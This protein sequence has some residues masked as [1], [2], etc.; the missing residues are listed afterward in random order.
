M[1][2]LVP[3]TFK[4]FGVTLRQVFRSRSR[5]S[6]RSSSGRST[7]ASAAATGCT[8]TR[9]GSR[10]ASA[11]RSAPPPARPT[12]SASSP[13]R[14]PPSNRVSP[15]ERYARIYEINMS[16]LHLLRLLRARLPVRRDHARQRLRDLRVQPRRPDL[17][18]GHAARRRRSSGCRSPTATSTT[19]RSRTTRRNSLTMANFIV[20]VRLGRRRVRL[21]RERDRRRQLPQP[22]LLGARADREPRLA[23]RALPAARRRVRRR[24]QVLVYG[25]AVM[26]MFLFVIAYLGDRT[27]QAPWAGGPSWQAVA[28]V[29][30]AGAIL[31]E[32]IVAVGAHDAAAGSR[33]AAPITRSFGSPAVDR[34]ALPDRPPARVRGHLDRA[35][36]RGGRRR[37][38]RLA[39]AH[40]REPGDGEARV[41][42]P[43]VAW[44]IVLAGMLFVDRRARRARS[45]AAR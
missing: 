42:G 39:R 35:A 23:R 41:H 16:P 36:R 15:G 4:G 14:T 21:P 19:R 7:R 27:D 24:G 9:T 11:A 18:Q 45:A 28:T 1:S 43:D 6:T 12:A 22:V 38:A 8:C 30:A 26:V 44:Y 32:V 29:L 20:W 25:G 17:H 5:S 2:A 40:D 3:N 37:R 34:P 13:P 31:V 33:H 10:S